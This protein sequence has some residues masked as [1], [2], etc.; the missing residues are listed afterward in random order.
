MRTT[1]DIEDDLLLATKE[2]ARKE[3]VSASK[4]EAGGFRPFTSVNSRIV[5]NNKVNQLRDDEGV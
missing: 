5:T 4:I 1:L 2:L 3:R